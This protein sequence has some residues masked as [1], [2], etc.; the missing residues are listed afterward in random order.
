MSINNE[1]MTG[2]VQHRRG[3]TEE[4][5]NSPI[6]PYE[7]E[8]VIEE[9]DDGTRR[10]K[11]GDGKHIFK[12]L[13]YVDVSS[14]A[15]VEALKS[16]VIKN[17]SDIGTTNTVL[18]SLKREVDGV[19]SAIKS[20]VDPSIEK[21]DAMYS[22]RLN[23]IENQHNEDKNELCEAIIEAKKEL[24]D[25]FTDKLSEQ[26]IAITE[27]V[28]TK[29]TTATS[30]LANQLK[31]SESGLQKQV[32]D[33][34]SEQESLAT[35]LDSL[36]KKVG[37]T[38]TS[39]STSLSR[40][41]ASELKI[42]ELVVELNKLKD[43][44]YVDFITA[45]MVGQLRAVEAKVDQLSTS[46]I[47]VV[48]RL[49]AA[50]ASIDK[51]T[52]QLKELQEYHN[53]DFTG[54]TNDF[55]NLRN[56]LREADSK[57]LEKINTELTKLWKE[58][59]DLVD[60][61]ISLYSHILTTRNNLNTRFDA[62]KAD[63]EANN[64]T[65]KK[66]LTET[67]TS[68]ETAI[69]NSIKV[70]SE[71][72]NKKLIDTKTE[73]ANG[74]STVKAIYEANARVVD[75]TFQ[76]L[77]QDLNDKHTEV[78]ERINDTVKKLNQN[79]VE[80]KKSFNAI[81]NEISEINK[82][83]IETNSKLEVEK[84]R[85]D[86]QAR[87]ISQLIRLEDGSTT[88]DAELVNARISHDGET[89]NTIG[90]HIR[91]VGAEIAD[92]RDSHKG[93]PHNTAKEAVQAISEDLQIL[94]NKFYDHTDSQA[95]TSLHYDVDGKVGLNEKYMLYLKNAEGDIIQES[96]VQIISGAPGTG[97]VG[98]GSGVSSLTITRIT[99]QIA[100][101]KKS[102]KAILEFTFSGVDSSGEPIIQASAEWKFNGVT[103]AYGTVT[104][105]IDNTF[106]ITKYL[107][108]GETKVLLKVTD[109]T[110]ST[111]TKDW[112]VRQIDLSLTS[113]FDDKKT[114]AA[115]ESFIFTYKPV[116]AI[117]KTL[118]LKLDGEEFDRI[119]LS[120][121]NSGSV[122]KYENSEK[123]TALSHGSHLLEAY[124]EAYING[125]YEPS[126][127]IFKD[128]LIKDPASRIPLIGTSTQQ[129]QTQQ[130]STTNIIVTVYDPKIESPTVDIW[131][132]DSLVLTKTIS[133]NS[134]YNNSPTY[135]Y[136]YPATEAGNHTIKVVCGEAEK[137][138]SIL[139]E[140]LNLEI[141][142]ITTGLAFDFNPAFGDNDTLW[143][144]NGISM[145]VSD[146]FDWINGGYI[147]DEENGPCFCIKAGSAATIAYNLFGDA[148]VK[149]T[150]KSFKLVFKTKNVSNADA[151]FL[152]CLDNTTESDHIGIKMGVHNA[153]IYGKTGALDLAYSEDDVIEFGFNISGAE[154][155]VKMVMG[156]EDGVPSRPMI[157]NDLHS[158]TQNNPKSITLGSADC[159]LYIYRLKA[160]NV[161]LTAEEI[162]DSFILDA[163]TPEEMLL[164]Y[165]RNRIYNADTL[166]DPDVLA[167]KCPHLRVYKLSAPW[168]TNNKSDKVPGTTIQQI[169]KNGDPVL[170]NW[171]CYNAQHSGQGTSSNNYGAAGRNLDFIMNKSGIEGVEPYFELG[172]GTRA[173]K[174][175]LTR[176][177]VPVAYLN[178]KVNIASSNNLTNAILAAKYNEFNPYRRPFVRE[179]K[180]EDSYSEVEI[181]G[182]TPEEQEAA[183]VKLQ[184]KVNSELIYIK[185]TME[186]HNCVIFIQETDT[187]LSTHREFADNDWHFYAIGNIGDSK[188]TD[189]TRLTDP[190]DKYEC[191]VEI[192]DVSLPLSDFPVDTMINATTY[193]S[194]TGEVVHTWAKPENIDILYEREYILTDDTTVDLNKTYYIDLP[195]KVTATAEQLSIEN[196]ENL[197]ERVYTLTDDVEVIQDKVYYLNSSGDLATKEYL[198]SIISPKDEGLYE[199]RRDYI[200]TNDL[201][202]ITGK[203]YY[204][205]VSEKT[206]AMSYTMTDI[207]DYIW[208]KTENLDILYEFIDED[209]VITEDTEVDL[210][211]TYYIKH[212]EKDADGNIVSTNFIDAMGY[213]V[214]TV[215]TY[216]WAK[217]EN[218]DRLYEVT[219]VKTADTEI[220]LTKTY[221]IDILEQDN[222][223]E[224]YTYGWRYISDDE[225][226]DVLDTCKQAWIDFY[227]FVTTATDDEFKQH[228]DKYFV[229]DSAL[230]Y[231]L[232]TT[233]YCMV[234]N[235]AKNTFWHYGKTGGFYDNAIEIKNSDGNILFTAT[236]GEP[237]R[238]WDLCWDYDNDTSLG[239]NNYGKQ[240]YR[241]GLEDTDYDEKGTEVFRES[242]STFFCRV[243]DL[244]AEE[245]KEMYNTLES[246]QAWH[247]ESFINKCDEWQE[248]FPEELW[249]LDIERKYIR[250]Y[251]RSFINGPADT[252]FLE[253]MSNGRMKYQRRQWERSQEKYMASKY[254]TSLAAGDTANAQFRA[255][256]P[257]AD[258]TGI[259]SATAVP[260]NYQFTLTPFSYMYLTVRY[261][262]TG[263]TPITVK[264]TEPGQP[265]VIPYSGTYDDLIY[266][267]S[268][269][270]ISD[271]GDLSPMYVQTA[272]IGNA[273]RVKKFKLGNDNVNYKNP[274]LTSL[275]T[276]TNPLLEELDITNVTGLTTALDLKSMTN[277]TRFLAFGSSIPG[278]LFAQGGKLA[279]AELPAVTTISLIDLK[280]LTLANFKLSDYSRVTD[281]TIEHCPKLGS[282]DSLLNACTAL[283]RVRLVG[284]D[285]GSYLYEDF[286]NKFKNL[287]GMDATGINTDNAWLSG[288]VHFTDAELSGAQYNE[289][290]TLYPEL[291]IT[292]EKLNSTLTFMNTDGETTYTDCQNIIDD[293]TIPK[294]KEQFDPQVKVELHAHL[295]FLLKY[296]RLN[297]LLYHK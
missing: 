246:K 21:L 127:S 278:V 153:N 77:K 126:D 83:F 236:A 177:S 4:W 212:E 131:V 37:V 128:I 68:K 132:D 134:D 255:G 8:L 12:H 253:N 65:I 115:G 102:D 33:L 259:A 272:S 140:S 276:G 110:G 93:I 42:D 213:T 144:Q 254:Q 239:L 274:N 57:N 227:R 106:D 293:P 244:F 104:A 280:F 20:I 18:S 263:T 123:F 219:Y 240:V 122:Q 264:V 249:R 13:S 26:A 242:D 267:Y 85:I 47:T 162:L 139:V 189:D 90:E 223:N 297:L 220:N 142:P 3:T 2:I 262:G 271:F 145:T 233:R 273:P 257:A 53:N 187:D 224:D 252:Q 25:E 89:Y 107:T 146:N 63:V 250:T 291:K 201:E 76:G 32:S 73:L 105:G 82:K 28:D 174:I 166:L 79:N 265:V 281:L 124:L 100:V 196:L 179:A 195:K 234:D 164:R 133:P 282:I 120:A 295:L 296:Y 176:E 78:T 256:S 226:P 182:M 48:N 190:S 101:F 218:L 170:D 61:D 241:Y 36:D 38:N 188:K 43:L 147:P 58:I 117:D 161:S 108:S 181:A 55:N 29:V 7:G 289:I 238:K 266:V 62:L 99:P 285:F 69:N 150:G 97:G 248:E 6:I 178:A 284:V 84:D 1:N 92:I 245:L 283:N 222:F 109:D 5:N 186:F 192:M 198:Q 185:D 258:S 75:R 197:F 277:L 217:N 286:I 158:F 270:N 74:I 294:D 208:A 157:Y 46:D 66:E 143:S 229:K 52:R 184:E 98:G 149:T 23:S 288:T 81:D 171:I 14:E 199:W 27:S 30:N 137:E 45:E 209:Y 215:K 80:V 15:A 136:P 268:A 138:I 175:T 230:F 151:V 287:K 40:I 118:V 103:K 112:R 86:S 243:R 16:Q 204:V 183:L 169:Y 67:L 10:A 71:T 235:R 114:Y 206:N 60:D 152:S 205:E 247:A 96:G 154:D 119:D 41:Q 173:D 275:T 88:G 72:L 111:V 159:D 59:T 135:V 168:F 141:S 194:E 31:A 279:Y 95:I 44:G 269:S 237:I 160:Y 210:D 155:S 203:I 292:Y 113:D 221:Y 172:N 125:V 200:K 163:R 129:I 91:A 54:I 261:G 228:F 202:I 22:A 216:T 225:D 191:C 50:Q 39:L 56:D 193:D 214:K 87:Q 19:S 9:C 121:S 116:G 211:K 180:L 251:T 70:N 290:K 34:K 35:N 49:Y 94:E 64:A 207:K 232:F 17:S 156:Y 167:E 51:L 11:I 231:Y 260:P 24:S 148:N 130:Y 165:N